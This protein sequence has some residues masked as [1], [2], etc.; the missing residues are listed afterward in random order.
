MGGSEEGLVMR[1]LYI[2]Q[3]FIITTLLLFIQQFNNYLLNT[4]KAPEMF[5]G[6]KNIAVKNTQ[7]AYNLMSEDR[8]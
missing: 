4:Y 6:A 7:G 8:H 1:N 3:P 2:S 5:L